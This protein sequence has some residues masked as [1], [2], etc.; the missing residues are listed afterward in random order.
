VVGVVLT[1]ARND[2]TAG[3]IAVKR[4]GGVAVVQDPEDALFPSMPEHALEYVDADHCVP[5]GKLA[6]C[7]IVSAASPRSQG[8]REE[9]TKA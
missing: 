6:P 8:G 9:L 5:L 4:R 7:W 2:G 3:L 1:G